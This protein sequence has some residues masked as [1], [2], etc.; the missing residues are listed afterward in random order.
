MKYVT[1]WSIIFPCTI[2]I[3][4]RL[5]FLCCCSGILSGLLYVQDEGILVRMINY[6]AML[7]L[8][9]FQISLCLIDGGIFMAITSMYQNSWSHVIWSPKFRLWSH[10]LG[11]ESLLLY[12]PDV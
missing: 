9:D 10:K 5:S 12:L 3:L 2:Y 4:S 6:M 11:F 7:I 8:T 1:G